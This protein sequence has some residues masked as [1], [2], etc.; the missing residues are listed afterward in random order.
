M[1]TALKVLCSM[2]TI[3]AMMLATVVLA[4]QNETDVTATPEYGSSAAPVACSDANAV[5]PIIVARNTN[6]C[7][8]GV[9]CEHYRCSEAFCCPWGYFYSNICTCRCYKSSY[10]AGANCSTYFRCN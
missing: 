6:P 4:G 8:G 10:D 9:Y 1:K 2:F 5:K 3:F 7:P